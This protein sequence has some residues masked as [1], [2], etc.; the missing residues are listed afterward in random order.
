MNYSIISTLG[1]CSQTDSIWE[2]M[3]EGGVTGF[4]LN[5][6]HMTVDELLQQLNVLEMFFSNRQSFFPVVLDLQGSKWRLGRFSPFELRHGQKIDFVHSDFAENKATLPVPHSDFFKAADRSSGQIILNDARNILSIEDIE[7]GRIRATVHQGGKIYP[8]KGITYSESDYRHESP[9]DKDLQII[10]RVKK[11]HFVQFAV[12]YI[13]D[14]L[15]MSKYRDVIG[16]WAVIIAK[17]ERQSALDDA[18]RIAHHSD[19]LWLC[20]GD[21][22]AEL[23]LRKMAIS[24]YNFNKR[25]AK[26]PGPVLLAG[27]VLH[28]MTTNSEP[29]RSEIVHLYDA[30]I[31]GYAGLVLSDETAIGRDPVKSCRYA[32]LFRTDV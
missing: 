9:G 12:S 21:L 16:T 4:R 32:A 29:T 20:R 6:S 30:L 25:I 31:Q 23:G 24:V 2:A 11:F 22:G 8:N 13:R 14:H 26:I 19:A 15:E 27:Q 7:P 10:K 17:L 3:L 18:M 1:P 28:H 5:T